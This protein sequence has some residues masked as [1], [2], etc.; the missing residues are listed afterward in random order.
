MV[1]C[2]MS[3]SAIA[4]SSTCKAFSFSSAAAAR[5]IRPSV[6]VMSGSSIPPEY[7]SAAARRQPE[8]NQLVT[9][10]MCPFGDYL[11]AE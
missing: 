2:C 6:I 5:R 7:A 8:S 1:G 10:K 9:N 4:S 3:I 11:V